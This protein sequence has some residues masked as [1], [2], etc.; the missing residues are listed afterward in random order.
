MTVSGAALAGPQK[1]LRVAHFRTR[2]AVHKAGW[3]G[4]NAAAYVQKGKAR[5][6]WIAYRIVAKTFPNVPDGIEDALRIIRTR[7]RVAAIAAYSF[8]T[9]TAAVC[10]V[11]V[12]VFTF[13][14]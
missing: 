1:A 14:T 9:V 5:G 12:T 7:A 13:L 11:C 2:L 6:E 8:S 10:L 3:E 4:G